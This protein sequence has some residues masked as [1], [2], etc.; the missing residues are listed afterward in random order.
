MGLADA[1]TSRAVQPHCRLSTQCPLEAIDLASDGGMITAVGNDLGFDD[2]F[3]RQ[4][5]ADGYRSGESTWLL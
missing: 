3:R 2:I 5:L 4:V 1:H